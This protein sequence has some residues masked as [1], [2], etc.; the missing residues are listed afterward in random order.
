MDR[1]DLPTSPSM[2]SYEAIKSK[3]P[4]GDQ[5]NSE[6]LHVVTP[7]EFLPPIGRWT[8]LGGLA[9]LAAFGTAITLATVLKYKVTVKS[10]GIVRPTGELRIVQ[11]ATE[12]T[13]KRIDIKA[14][15]SVK[16]GDVIAHI[17]DSRLQTKK[18][19]LTGNIEQ[20]K[21]QLSQI[22]AQ[23]LAIDGR[24]TA[25]TDQLKRIIAAARAELRLNQRNY[26]DRRITTIAEL[27]KAEAALE[28]AQEELS[29]YQKLANTGVIAQLQIKEKEANVK[30][31]IARVKKLRTYLNPSNAEVE[32]AREKIAKA[33]A[34]GEATL[35]KL[36]QER[37]GRVKRRIE[38]QNQMSSYSQELQQIATELENTIVRAPTSG[39]IQELNL[40]NVS[41]MVRP[42]E[43]IALISPS[44]TPLEIKALV[45][46]GDIAKV[47]V[48]QKV[49]IRVSACPY[50]DYG[51]LNGTVS[52]IAPDATMPQNNSTSSFNSSL[53]RGIPPAQT[54]QGGIYNVIIQP[55]SLVLGTGEQKCQIQSGMEGKADIISREETVLTF[56]LRKT[57][58]LTDF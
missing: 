17:D 22:N 34:K 36:K 23:L 47:E 16:K 51:T 8:T 45:A 4:D 7:D 40:R 11:A 9:L 58:L 46:S 24:I 38:I 56:L 26:R 20:R 52:F 13:V 53:S 21:K 2:G 31:S 32:M 43:A 39:E 37:Q 29:R 18:N 15:Q 6:F 54:S 14:N 57:R 35:A 1:E 12:G 49:Q 42:G 44:N 25:E 10:P 50:P 48:G 5:F 55:D 27:E 41:Q 19:Q 30:T 28:L 33:R 3:K